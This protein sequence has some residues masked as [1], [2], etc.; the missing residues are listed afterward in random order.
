[1]LPPFAPRFCAPLH[2]LLTFTRRVSPPN[3][4]TPDTPDLESGTYYV[5]RLVVANV[6][7]AVEGMPTEAMR[8]P[9]E[10][11]FSEIR[12]NHTIHARVQVTRQDTRLPGVSF[13]IRPP[14]HLLCCTHTPS[15]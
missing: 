14:A 10:G 3:C 7:G 12:R 6:Y 5:F 2:I 15:I 4:G 13:F 9:A 8:T 11:M 1:V